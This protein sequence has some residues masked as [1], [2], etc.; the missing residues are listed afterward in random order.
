MKLTWVSTRPRVFLPGVV[1]VLVVLVSLGCG[2]RQSAQVILTAEVPL[3]LEDHL[4]A[5]T[6]EGSEVP[7]DVPEAVEWLFDEPQAEWKPVGYAESTPVRLTRL[8]DAL[9]LDIT[10]ANYFTAQTGTRAHDGWIYVDLPDLR[11]E[12]WGYV[13]VRARAQPGV[14]G[15]GLWFNLTDRSDPSQ[16]P[17]SGFTPAGGW[18][19]RYYGDE[20]PLIADGLVHTYLLTVREG[21]DWDE[22]LKQIGLRFFV[23]S[24]PG[25]VP[26]SI[27]ILSVSLIPKEAAYADADVGVAH[28]FSGNIQRRELYTHAPARLE[29][30]VRVPDGGRFDVG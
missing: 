20:A 11:L 29:Y 28:A 9:R 14:Q 24:Q 12:D 2:D 17:D 7:T 26:T 19:L 1:A 16:T 5:A 25:R 3:H 30:R 21:Q 23:G 15:V 6:I 4:D 13:S 22:P 27:D 10:E 18:P 8:D